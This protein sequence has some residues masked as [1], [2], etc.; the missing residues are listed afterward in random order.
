MK[1]KLVSIP[2][3]DPIE[4]F[5]FY[6]KVLNF[7][8]NLY[9]PEAKLAIIVSPEDPKGTAVLLEPNENPITKNFQEAV[10]ESG[11]PVMVFGVE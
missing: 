10:R 1:V 6:T 7:Q 9:M 3:N 2:V 5:Q 11:L 8:E 4:A